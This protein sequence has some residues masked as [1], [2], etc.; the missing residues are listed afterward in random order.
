MKVISVLIEDRD[1]VE[2]D[3]FE[4]C[5]EQAAESKIAKVRVWYPNAMVTR[6]EREE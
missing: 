4:T 5:D 2:L 6:T 1:G 3:R